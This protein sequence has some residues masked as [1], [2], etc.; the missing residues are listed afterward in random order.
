MELVIYGARQF[1]I[2]EHFFWMRWLLRSR[3]FMGDFLGSMSVPVAPVAQ[4]YHV[5]SD[6]LGLEFDPGKRD[7]SH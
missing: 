5:T 3:I 1:G 7:F 6:T 4:R 2:K